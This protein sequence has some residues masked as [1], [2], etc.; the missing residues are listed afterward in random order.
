[1]FVNLVNGIPIPH[2]I[3]VF[4]GSPVLDGKHPVGEVEEYESCKV[5]N[6]VI[7]LLLDAKPFLRVKGHIMKLDQ[8]G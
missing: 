7:Q 4:G 1:M 5:E 6:V 8:G 3:H 2:F